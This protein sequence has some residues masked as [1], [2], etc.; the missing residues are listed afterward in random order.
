M[1]SSSYCDPAYARIP[2]IVPHE[3][4]VRMSFSIEE[5]RPSTCAFMAFG[6]YV[7][8]AAYGDVGACRKTFDA[9]VAACRAYE[10]RLSTRLPHSDI[11][12]LNAAKGR[13]VAVHSE[14]AGII[15]AAKRYCALSEGF[16]DITVQ[17]AVKLWDFQRGVLPCAN[18][19]AAAASHINWRGVD[20]VKKNGQ[21]L[22][23]LSDPEAQVDLGGI[24]KGWIADRLVELIECDKHEVSGIVGIKVNLGGNVAVK[25]AKPDGASWV[26]GVRDPNNPAEIIATVEVSEGAV[27][28]SGTY[29]RCFLSGGRLYH[30]VL[31]P[32]TGAPVSTDMASASVVARTA[33]DAEGFSTT[34]LALGMERGCAFT[35]SEPSI[36]SAILIGCGGRVRIVD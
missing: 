15:E 7:E 35:E 19:L 8:I 12:R 31:D 23:R 28:T 1:T 17:P 5:L 4:S 10:R 6:T 26:V 2:D 14:T 24:A 11:A 33:L 36:C 25:G 30:H 18:E 32:K 22:V 16:F 13:A 21:W 20:V 3:A 34:L 9:A 27:V 29:E